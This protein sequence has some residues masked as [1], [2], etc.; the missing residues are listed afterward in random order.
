[1]CISS[2]IIYTFNLAFYNSIV[3]IGIEKTCKIIVMIDHSC[4][5]NFVTVSLIVKTLYYYYDPRNNDI[6]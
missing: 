6:D 1:M 4:P 3:C 2:I 5:D